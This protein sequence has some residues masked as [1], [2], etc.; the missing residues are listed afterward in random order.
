M[1]DRL[2]GERRRRIRSCV[3]LLLTAI[4]VIAAALA[5]AGFVVSCAVEDSGSIRVGRAGAIR[6]MGG[7]MGGRAIYHVTINGTFRDVCQRLIIRRR[8]FLCLR[9]WVGRRR[10]V[11]FANRF[12]AHGHWQVGAAHIDALRQDGGGDCVGDRSGIDRLVGRNRSRLPRARRRW[13]QS[14][15]VDGVATCRCG[16]QRLCAEI[17]QADGVSPDGVEDEVFVRRQRFCSVGNDARDLTPPGRG[18]WRRWSL[19]S[20]VQVMAPC[21]GTKVIVAIGDSIS[22]GSAI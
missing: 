21:A 1:F 16:D 5:L 18:R 4:L 8:G 20:D 7:R 12:S 3:P 6:A 11:K 22:D 19:L 17:D 15:D 14:G 13:S 10:Q 9:S 2:N